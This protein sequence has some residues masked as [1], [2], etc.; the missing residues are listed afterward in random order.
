[1][2]YLHKILPVFL[3]PI[4]IVLVLLIIGLLTRKRRWIA[5]ATS[6]LYII[7]MPVVADALFRQIEGPFE[8]LSPSEVPEV[9]AIVV[10]SAGMRWVQTKNGLI[11]E[12]PSPSR[13]FGG[14]E[15][16]NAGRAPLLVF[17]GGK[18]P[19]QH[20][21]ETEGLVLKRHAEQITGVDSQKIL[22]SEKAENTEQEASSVSKLLLPTKNKII[23]VTSAFHMLRAKNLFEHE[24]FNVFPYPVHVRKSAENMTAL[25]FLPDPAALGA[26][27]TAIHELFGRGFYFLKNL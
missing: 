13:F 6:F 27:N 9:D 12:W 7:S 23:L 17:T 19:W 4:V 8:R 3:S 14:I 16:L 25:K 15:L 18:L 5:I 22:L 11:A 26:T 24:G 21:D 1:M 10:L 2:I 20:G